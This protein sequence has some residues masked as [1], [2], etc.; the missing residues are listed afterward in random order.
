MDHRPKTAEQ[1][2]DRLDQARLE[3]G[4]LRV[5]DEYDTN[6]MGDVLDFRSLLER[7]VVALKQVLIAGRYPFGKIDLPFMRIVEQQSGRVLSSRDLLRMVNATH[8]LRLNTG[9]R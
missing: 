2:V 8:L 5:A 1:H 7:D 3:F 4:D 9:P 6:S